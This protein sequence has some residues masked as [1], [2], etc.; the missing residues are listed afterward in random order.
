MKNTIFFFHLV[1]LTADLLTCPCCPISQ[2]VRA[3]VVI[4]MPINFWLICKQWWV[5]NMTQTITSFYYLYC[6]LQKTLQSYI[7]YIYCAW[8]LAV[9]TVWPLPPKYC[10]IL[11]S[12]QLVRAL[13][14]STRA[15]TQKLSK[16]KKELTAAA[17]HCISFIAPKQGPPPTYWLFLFLFALRLKNFQGIT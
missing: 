12:S 4:Y 3:R 1:K 15:F 6:K 17:A 11:H 7:A 13:P 16:A 8:P 2:I 9:G 5:K 10:A 14:L